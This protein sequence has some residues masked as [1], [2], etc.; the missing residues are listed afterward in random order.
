MN[1]ERNGW[2]HFTST[3]GQLGLAV[4]VLVCV[5]SLFSAGFLFQDFMVKKLGA[6]QVKTMKQVHRYASLLIYITAMAEVIVSFYTGWW[7]NAVDDKIWMGAT[8][9]VL[10]TLAAVILQVGTRGVPCFM[11]S[12]I[13]GARRTA[14]FHGSTAHWRRSQVRLDP[15]INIDP[16]ARRPLPPSARSSASRCCRKTDKPE[17][18]IHF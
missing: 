13:P 16:L 15:L 3:H 4:T 17:N 12:R 9:L 18:G 1:K 8:G 2:P 11:Q 14:P 6:K 5:Q 10:V 7:K